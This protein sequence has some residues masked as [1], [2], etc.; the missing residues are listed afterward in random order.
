MKLRIARY[1]TLFFAGMIGMLSAA[2]A[3]RSNGF[4]Y[5][6]P[7]GASAGGQTDGTLQVG[8]G[9]EYVSRIGVGVMGEGGALAYLKEYAGTVVATFSVGGCYHLPLSGRK[10]DPYGVVGY[11]VFTRFQDGRLNTVHF[12]AGANYWVKPRLGIKVEFRDH[13]NQPDNPV[14]YWGIRF[15]VTLR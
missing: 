11:G 15:G 10:W 7:G 14:Q 1:L 3:A 9:R 6:S 5:A 13:I 4:F 12:G 8:A 2:N